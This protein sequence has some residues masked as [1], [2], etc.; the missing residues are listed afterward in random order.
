M[1]PQTNVTNLRSKMFPM[2]GIEPGPLRWERQI[3]ATR[4]YGILIHIQRQVD[5][6]NQEAG[7]LKVSKL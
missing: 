2:P 1:S 4:T 5:A 3:L 6:P 7:F